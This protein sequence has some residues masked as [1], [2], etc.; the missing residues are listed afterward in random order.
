M[1]TVFSF[2]LDEEISSM[3]KIM[4]MRMERS[5]GEAIRWLIHKAASEFGLVSPRDKQS[6]GHK[7]NVHQAFLQD[8]NNRE[9]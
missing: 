3:L 2:R 4:A 1:K 8:E 5:R 6:N 9:V 7:G